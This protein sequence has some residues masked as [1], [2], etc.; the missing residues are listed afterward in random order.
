MHFLGPEDK[1]PH[2]RWHHRGNAA[3]LKN[4]GC[5]RPVAHVRPHPNCED[6]DQ[7]NDN[8]GDQGEVSIG[9]FVVH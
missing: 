7:G 5:C 2:N 3:F 6:H 4:G 8:A 9:V 1:F